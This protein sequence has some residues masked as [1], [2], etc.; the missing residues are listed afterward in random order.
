MLIE[1]AIRTICKRTKQ[2]TYM[3]EHGFIKKNH[4]TNSEYNSY[5]AR[6]KKSEDITTREK[7][8]VLKHNTFEAM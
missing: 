4:R 8:Y 3:N 5:S 7:E 6:C 1:I 2:A